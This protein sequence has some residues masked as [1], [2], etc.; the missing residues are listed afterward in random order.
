MKLTRITAAIMVGACSTPAMAEDLMQV[1]AMSLKSDPQ[2]LAEAA[3]QRAISE[4]EVQAKARFLPQ[5]DL[6]A[7]N[8]LT[9]QDT[10]SRSFSGDTD[11]NSHGYNLSITQPVYHK[12]NFVQQ[13]QADI[14]IESAKASYQVKEQDLIIRVAEDYFDLLGQQADLSFAIA[15]REAIAL[16]LEQTNQRF[17]VGM[18][19]ITDV[20]ESQAAYDLAIASVIDAENEVANSKERLRETSGAYVGTLA[21]LNAESPLV[22]PEPQNIDQWTELAL[23]QNPNLVVARSN[24]ENARQE[25][26]LQKSGHYP[27]LDLVGQKNYSSQSDTTTGGGSKVH[28]DSISLQFSLPI[29]SGG[30]VTS[31][32]RAAGHRLDQ[33]MQN[34]EQQLRSVSR[35][36]REAYNGV[37]SGISRVKAL[38]QAVISNEKALESTEAGYEV[39]TRTTVDV[40]IAR[41]ELFSARRDYSNSR[42][43]YTVNVLR[44]KQ[45]AGTVTEEDLAQI[46]QWLGGQS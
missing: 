35:Q 19:T 22:S 29:Y 20:A 14:A 37:M 45:A 16:Q 9:N 3:S 23:A 25:I 30:S 21:E 46:N 12:E 11:Y 31:R 10:S 5:V 18:V 4:L 38:K 42:Y 6:S 17:D 13:S 27:S 34:E 39:G 24:I 36:T 28:Q 40:L 26:A 44:L 7:N 1:Y 2:L 43:D 41:Q 32:S 33:A 8:G 15:E